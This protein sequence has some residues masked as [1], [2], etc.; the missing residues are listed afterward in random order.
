MFATYI[1]QSTE[2]SLWLHSTAACKCEFNE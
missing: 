2:S 1:S